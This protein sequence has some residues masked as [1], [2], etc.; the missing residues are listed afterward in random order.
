MQRT[1][2]LYAMLKLLH[3]ATSFDLLLPGIKLDKATLHADVAYCVHIDEVAD[4][5]CRPKQCAVEGTWL[6]TELLTW[7]GLV[8][9]TTT[10][11]V[12]VFK[13]GVDLYT[14]SNSTQLTMAD[15]EQLWLAVL[16]AAWL[17]ALCAASLTSHAQQDA[18][19]AQALRQA[20]LQDLHS[21]S[22]AVVLQLCQHAARV[23]AEYEARVVAEQ[24]AAHT[25]RSQAACA[26]LVLMC[27]VVQSEATAPNKAEITDCMMELSAVWGGVHSSLPCKQVCMAA[28]QATASVQ[29]AGVCMLACDGVW[30]CDRHE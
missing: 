3:D 27:S 21:T 10:Y 8:H 25:A 16:H 26:E 6:S 5:T 30:Q 13:A 19:I 23:A 1:L 17:Q 29:H 4:P 24:A 9:H 12:H 2:L 28:D 18:A 20:L 15:K 11:E 14:P 7:G 22:R